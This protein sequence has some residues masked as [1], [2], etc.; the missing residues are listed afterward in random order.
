MQRFRRFTP[1]G[2]LKA[3]ED[4]TTQEGH[5]D[6]VTEPKKKTATENGTLNPETKVPR[7]GPVSGEVT[8]DGLK[9]VPL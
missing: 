5:D 8:G 1:F 4:R 7:G 3:H 9:R 2:L 6:T